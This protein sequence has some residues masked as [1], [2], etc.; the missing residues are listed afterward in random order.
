MVC[1]FKR[2]TSSVYKATEIFK[3]SVGIKTVIVFPLTVSSFF[4]FEHHEI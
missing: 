3:N 1:I 4:F 2:M